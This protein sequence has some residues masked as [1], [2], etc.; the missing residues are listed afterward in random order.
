MPRA[1]GREHVLVRHQC[2]RRGGAL[3]QEHRRCLRRRHRLRVRRGEGR[4]VLRRRMRTHAAPDSPGAAAAGAHAR[5]H[6]LLLRRHLRRGERVHARLRRRPRR[7]LRQGPAREQVLGIRDGVR[8]QGSYAAARPEPWV[9]HLLLRRHV[10]GCY[11]VLEQVPGRPRRHVHGR[12]R[13]VLGQGHLRCAHATPGADAAH[14]GTDYLRRVPRAAGACGVPVDGVVLEH[15]DLHG[16]RQRGQR[17]LRV[18]RRVPGTE[19][20]IEVVP[21]PSVQQHELRRS[22]TRRRPRG[23]RRTL[24]RLHR[25]SKLT[26]RGDEHG[27]IRESISCCNLGGLS[28]D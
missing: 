21:L 11:C 25:V 3:R 12:R 7:G 20:A 23:H 10:P 2:R 1:D 18:P 14:A 8:T 6:E 9:R 24:R 28:L 22:W 19:P 13:E 15:E 27:W 4:H 17:G 16:S 26:N 5:L